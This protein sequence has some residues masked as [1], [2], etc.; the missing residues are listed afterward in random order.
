MGYGKGK[1]KGGFAAEIGPRVRVTA[2]RVTGTLTEWKG[3]M[4][5][6]DA[7]EEIDH[8]EASLRKGRIYLGQEDVEA[9]ISGPGATVSFFVYADGTGLGA[10]NVRPASGAPVQKQVAKRWAPPAAASARPWTAAAAKGAALMKG[11]AKGGK[12]GQPAPDKESRE[13]LSEVPITGVVTKVNGKV[14][15]IKP[16][17]PVEHELSSKHKGQIYLHMQDMDD[18]EEPL[19]GAQVIFYTYADDHGLGAERCTIC[20]QGDGTYEGAEPEEANGE[21]APLGA[22]TPGRGRGKGK[23]KGFGGGFGGGGAK[24]NTG[25]D[26]PRERITE[27]PVMGELVSWKQKFGWIQPS[28]PIDHPMASKHKGQ[29]YVH[30]RDLQGEPDMAE[31]KQFMFHV[32][33]DASGLGAEECIAIG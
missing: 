27:E 10:M 11:A 20:Q 12:R 32:F 13:I 1:G 9:E 21:E 3:K 16:D 25:P 31:A 15:F 6:I 24:K 30:V 26:L 8:P 23:G 33:A 2:H 22:A 7:F 17:E 28:E 19:V 18:S 4:G 29:I 14:A 5:W